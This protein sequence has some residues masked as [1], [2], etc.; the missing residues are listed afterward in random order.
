MAQNYN[1]MYRFSQRCIKIIDNLICDAKIY[2]PLTATGE[3]LDELR[4]RICPLD[5][6]TTQKTMDMLD[7]FLPTQFNSTEESD[8]GYKLWFY[9]FMKLWEICNN[10]PAWEHSMMTLMSRLAWYNIGYIDW[11]PYIPIM[12]TRFMRCLNL[13][14]YYKNTKI[15]KPHKIT[16]NSVA[17]WVVS[18]LGNGSSG[19]FHLE[20]F[21]KT[22]ETYLH[23]ANIGPWIDGLKDF[24]S[25]LT[26][27]FVTRLHNERYKKKTWQRTT[28]DSHKLN[29]NDVDA[30]VKCMMPVAMTAMFGHT[31]A[32]ATSKVFRHLAT[33][34]PNLV[35]P[36][37]LERLYLTLDSVTEPHKLTAAMSAITAVAR[38]LVQG[39]RNIHQGYTYNEG[40]SRVVPLLFSALPGID[41]NDFIKCFATFRLISVYVSLVPIV[42]CSHATG[43]TLIDEDDRLVCE[44][45]SQF[46]DFVLQFFD[47][48]FTL[49]ESSTLEYVSQENQES[50][51]KSRVESMIELSLYSICSILLYRCSTNIFQAAL[52]KLRMFVTEKVLETRISGPLAASLCRSFARVNGRE[53]LKAL[54]PTLSQTIIEIME[55]SDVPKEENLDDRLLYAMLLVANLTTA[56]GHTLLPYKNTLIELL[57]KILHLK[58]REGSRISSRLLKGVLRSLST[59]T[60]NCGFTYDGR[61]YNNSTY[62][63]IL[64]WGQGVTLDS[65][66]IT[67]YVPGET[68][69]ATL[70]EFFNRYMSVEMEKIEKYCTTENSIT[71][72]ELLTTMTIIQAIIEGVSNYL[73]ISDEDLFNSDQASSFFPD[74]G[75][76]GEIKMPDGS[77]VKSSIFKLMT[78][79]QLKMLENSEDDPKSLTVLPRIWGSL[80]LGEIRQIE[81]H[82]RHILSTTQVKHELRDDLV[83]ERRHMAE[84]LLERTYLQH[85]I[86]RYSRF[87]VL[88]DFHK[89]IMLQLFK[90]SISTYAQVRMNAQDVLFATSGYFSTSRTAFIPEILELLAKDPEDHHDAHKGLLY[91]LAGPRP[92]AFIVPR[93]WEFLKTVWPALIFSKPSEKPSVIRLKNNLTETISR[94]MPTLP[95]KLCIADKCVTIAGELWNTYPKPLIIRPDEDEINKGID[96]LSQC[97]E[98]NKNNYDELMDSIVD[99][100]Q[101]NCHWRQRSMGMRILR[102]LAHPDRNYPTKVVNYF[103]NAL[104]HDILQERKIAILTVTCIMQ[105]LKREHPKIPINTPQLSTNMVSIWEDESTLPGA[106][107]DNAWL[108][109]NY[110]NRPLTKEQWNEPRYVHKQF[111]GYYT[112]PKELETYAPS[113]QQPNLDPHT[114][115]FTESEKLI[116]NFFADFRNIDKLVNFNSIEERK[117][118]DKFSNFRFLFYKGLFR[119]HGITHLDN[120]LPHLRR[121]VRDKQESHQLCAAEIIAGIIRGS[122][123]WTFEMVTTMWESLLPI[124][125]EALDNINTETTSDW[126][127]CFGAAVAKRDPNRHHWLFECLM[128]ESIEKN[129]STASLHESTMLFC[130]QSALLQQTWRLSELMKRLLARVETRLIA[131][132]FQNVRDC[133]GSVLTTIFAADY[134]PGSAKRNDSLALCAQDL[135]NRYLPQLLKLSQDDN[136][137]ELDGKKE[138]VSLLKAL[139]K[140]LITNAYASQHGSLPGFSL[141]LPVL[142]QLENYE[143]DD[144]LR[145]TCR[146]A[147]ATLAQALRLPRD[148]ET[149]F[150]DLLGVSNMSSWSARASCL[151]FIEV[152]VFYNMGVILN[153]KLWTGKVLE[154]VLRLLADERVEVRDKAGTVLCGLLH[155]N[156]IADQET[157]LVR[158]YC[159]LFYFSLIL[160]RFLSVIKYFIGKSFIH[161]MFSLQSELKN[162]SKM[163]IKNLDD[164]RVRHAGVLG[165]CSFIRAHPYDLPKYVPSIFEYLSLRLND[166]QPIPVSLCIRFELCPFIHKKFYH[167]Y[168]ITIFFFCCFV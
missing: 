57:D 8:K 74:V 7:L 138:S 61:D 157:L 69:I 10:A 70:Q 37:V 111:I 164:L 56:S 79:L 137:L 50:G 60:T 95:I 23:Q 5:V 146:R 67:W 6:R 98:K 36:D 105:Q 119:N 40:P 63:Y 75:V 35:I 47:R 55:E 3:I 117:G 28:P 156:F 34:R 159:V 64:D 32:V 167:V 24:L 154:I 82:K 113:S 83:K 91:L 72:S 33:I 88:T 22:I 143:P 104:I 20:K 130:I 27:H 41:A 153:N 132:P 121:L 86:R 11:E 99:R 53:T 100:I 125:R 127:L 147:L 108:Q 21:L 102:D 85:E 145:T 39:K 124:I 115:V 76:K 131:N 90:L 107:P 71:R 81:Q 25:K 150:D 94:Y 122:K 13:P 30:F 136:S 84:S 129:K 134:D 97:Q 168:H 120:F 43:S 128:E 92:K 87:Y 103:L 139:C 62:P 51:G 158:F 31:N 151:G 16:T 123:H 126:G 17:I 44:E 73:P 149:I 52:H 14:V 54:L 80:L 15:T 109:Y 89:F 142:C 59:I 152:F 77:N 148:M 110:D 160:F 42:D 12:T 48:I 96:E 114:R 93:D 18:I 112:W 19:Q 133:L 29:D 46:E 78:R 45:T 101:T 116:E 65:L 106:R 68:E 144:E 162:K 26:S 155:C 135:M 2:F 118:K 38:P 66:D 9:E 49:I 161:Y 165:L 4:P 163:K 141:L 166:P 1:C 140:W 58:S